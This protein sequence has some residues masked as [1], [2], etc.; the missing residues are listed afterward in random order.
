[1]RRLPEWLGHAVAT[2]RHLLPQ[3]C[4][5][6]RA[7]SAL[8]M[9]CEP[10]RRTLPRVGPACARCALPCAQ[11]VCATCARSPP[12]WRRAVAAWRYAYPMDRLLRGLKYAGQLALAEPLAD[13]LADALGEA[14][15]DDRPDAVVPLP[16]APRRQRERGFDQARLIASRVAQRI[17]VPLL[18]ALTRVRDA[19]PQAALP[20]AAREANVRDAFA[21]RCSVR[22][23]RVA[24]VDDVLTTGA[25][26][27][28]AARV[29][30]RAGAADIEAWVVARTLPPQ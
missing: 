5:L 28:S 18:P 23:M 25:T 22:G 11:A 14:P 6:C 15:A 20:L 17:G 27:S 19:G 21:M 26:L 9:L 3:A 12:P 24:L 2:G 29:L 4:A 16:L 1:M 7:P 10:C 30:K 8:A 13:G